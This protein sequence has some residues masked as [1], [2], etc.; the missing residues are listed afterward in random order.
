MPF[1]T[2]R[3][4][5]SR[6]SS[7]GLLSTTITRNFLFFSK[8]S[9]R[10]WLTSDELKIKDSVVEENVEGRWEFNG[11]DKKKGR[12]SVEWFENKILGG[13]HTVRVAFSAITLSNVYF[14]ARELLMQQ[15]THFF[16]FPLHV[17]C[18]WLTIRKL[19]WH[20]HCWSFL[21]STWQ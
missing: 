16:F 14:F 20:L 9:H 8:A 10:M 11:R 21:L 15:L 18:K 6:P 12:E 17:S 7:R 19:G 4:R 5:A 13:T 3:L 1:W 2:R